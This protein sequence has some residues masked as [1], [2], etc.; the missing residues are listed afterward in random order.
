[1]KTFLR[2]DEDVQVFIDGGSRGNP[3]SSGIGIVFSE[4]NKKTGFYF[5][6]G[7]STNNEAEYK[8]LIK[9]LEISKEKNIYNL[10]VYS[11]SE[12]ICNQMNGIYKIKN[13]R[14]QDLSVKVK[15]I[16]PFFKNFSISY[17]P[18]E[19]NKDA[20]KMANLA[21]DLI[22]DGVVELTAAG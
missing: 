9:A 19:K 11:D 8:A 7:V 18:R 14:L 2:H 17:I 21:M 1:L 6:N 20:D 3:G 15:E 22:K 16:L 10:S 5:Y 12:L 13:E 4:K